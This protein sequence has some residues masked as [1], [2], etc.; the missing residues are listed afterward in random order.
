VQAALPAAR[1]CKTDGNIFYDCQLVFITSF[2]L[3]KITSLLFDSI[4]ATEI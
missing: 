1:T 4:I 2:F 3:K